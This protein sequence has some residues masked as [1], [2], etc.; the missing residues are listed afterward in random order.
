MSDEKVR[1]EPW[2]N[3][4]S[5]YYLVSVKQRLEVEFRNS[6]KR[7]KKRHAEPKAQRV[8]PPLGIHKDG[9]ADG[10]WELEELL[11]LVKCSTES[12]GS[13]FK[14]EVKKYLEYKLTEEEIPIPDIYNL[15]DE[16]ENKF[17]DGWW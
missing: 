6:L 13:K 7:E 1:G 9:G 4:T 14:K 8:I 10:S 11:Y 2:H 15:I 3:R 16:K 5:E 12:L 17:N